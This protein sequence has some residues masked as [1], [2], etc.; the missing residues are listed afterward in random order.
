[1]YC[2]TGVEATKDQ[3]WLQRLEEQGKIYMT[4][5]RRLFLPYFEVIILLGTFRTIGHAHY[6]TENIII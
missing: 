4:G 6:N 3:L 1:M 5:D 2:L